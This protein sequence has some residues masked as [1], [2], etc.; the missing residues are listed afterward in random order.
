VGLSIDCDAIHDPF[1][2]GGFGHSGGGAF[3]LG[4]LN[5][6]G[7]FHNAVLNLVLKA[8]GIELGAGKLLLQFGGNCGILGSCCPKED[9]DDKEGK[10]TQHEHIVHSNSPFSHRSSAW[11]SRPVM[12]L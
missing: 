11:T 6:A 9:T 1:C 10:K 4:Y 8:V 3:T 12:K 7:P 5:R 2:S